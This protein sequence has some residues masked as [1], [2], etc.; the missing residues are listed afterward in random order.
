M[1]WEREFQ[2]RKKKE[3]K[4]LPKGKNQN[5]LWTWKVCA[6]DRRPTNRERGKQEAMAEGERTR[7]CQ[8]PVKGL[9]FVLRGSGKLREMQWPEFFKWPFPLHIIL[10]E[11]DSVAFESQILSIFY[12]DSK[13]KFPIYFL[14]TLPNGHHLKTVTTSRRER[15]KAGLLRTEPSLLTLNHRTF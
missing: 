2:R 5:Y 3:H 4:C 12:Q 14:Q 13:T 11:W 15:D 6:C 8:S 9:G 10:E 7:V 1:S